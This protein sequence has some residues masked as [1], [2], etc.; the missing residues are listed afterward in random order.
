MKDFKYPYG[1]TKF[2]AYYHQKG[3]KGAH[4]HVPRGLHDSN[5]LFRGIL[6]DD[7]GG[8]RQ[9]RVRRFPQGK[10]PMNVE[11][12]LV[13]LGPKECRLDHL[14]SALFRSL[15]APAYWEIRQKLTSYTLLA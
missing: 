2:R 3:V 4:H 13:E 6:A 15:R 10:G 1:S 9:L 8:N 7:H 5:A 14:H 11:L 12:C